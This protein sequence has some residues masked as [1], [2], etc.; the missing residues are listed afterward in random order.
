MGWLGTRG[1]SDECCVLRAGA[2]NGKTAAKAMDY[3]TVLGA[4]EGDVPEPIKRDALWRMR[5]YRLTFFASLRLTVPPVSLA[6]AA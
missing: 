4:W 1:S 6:A 3:N 2:V 5:A